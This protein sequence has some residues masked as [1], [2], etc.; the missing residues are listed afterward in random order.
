MMKSD[1]ED[2]E[3]EENNENESEATNEAK[4]EQEVEISEAV[5]SITANTTHRGRRFSFPPA[6]A[7]SAKKEK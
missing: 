4:R 3:S 7:R 5:S 6:E 2:R 1:P